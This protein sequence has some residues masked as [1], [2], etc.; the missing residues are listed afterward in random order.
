MNNKEYINLYSTFA[1]ELMMLKKKIVQIIK[2]LSDDWKN[3]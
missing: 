1:A 3:K 2:Q